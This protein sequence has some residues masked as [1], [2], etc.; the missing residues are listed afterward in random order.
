MEATSPIELAGVEALEP[1]GFETSN[2]VQREGPAIAGL[3]VLASLVAESWKQV[4][5]WT[6]DAAWG[7]TAAVE[8]LACIHDRYLPPFSRL[9]IS[10]ALSFSG[11]SARDLS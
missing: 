1:D 10:L 9:N 8:A 2:G 3:S 6:H 5:E 7:L 4:V 11:F